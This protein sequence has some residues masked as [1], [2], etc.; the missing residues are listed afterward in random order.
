MIE[1]TTIL[2]IMVGLFVL[3]WFGLGYVFSELRHINKTEEN[4]NNK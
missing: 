3:C 1:V 2:K 4:G